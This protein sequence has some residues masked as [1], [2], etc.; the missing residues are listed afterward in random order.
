MIK[1]H[2]ELIAECEWYL[3][4]LGFSIMGKDVIVRPMIQLIPYIR[5]DILVCNISH[6]QIPV[7]CGSLGMRQ[8][9]KVKIL[10][11][12]FP[13]I[14]WY[15]I[16]GLLLKIIPD[17]IQEF[18]QPQSDELKLICFRCG[19][20]W[21]PSVNSPKL[22]PSC[23]S[24]YWNTRRDSTNQLKCKRCNY[25]WWSRVEIPAAC[26]KC[27]SPYWNKEKLEKLLKEEK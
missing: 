7:E 8:G 1:T 4:K 15:P 19:H 17:Q 24:P 5:V 23:H 14:Y 25:E 13:F 18:G 22:C 27:H 16:S 21:F 3:T 11:D 9:T 20:N 10:F 26:P 6:N 12:K 2:N